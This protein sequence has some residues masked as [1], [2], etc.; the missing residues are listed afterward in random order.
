MKPEPDLAEVLGRHGWWKHRPATLDEIAAIE[1]TFGG[2]LPDDYVALL[3]YSN[4]GALY[5]FASPLCV[6]PTSVVLALHR[7]HDLYEDR[8]ACLIFGG[9]GGGTL[10]AFDLRHAGHRVIV[11]R[12]DLQSRE[13]L[14]FSADRLLDLI[15]AVLGGR[16]VN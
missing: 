10:Y 9:D 12:Q 3:R 5:G 6:F 16:K 2:T 11:F 13:G 7:E 14:L 15:D 4:G 8:P 1:A